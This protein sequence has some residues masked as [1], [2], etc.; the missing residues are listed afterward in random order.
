MRILGV[1]SLVFGFSRGKKFRFLFFRIRLFGWEFRFRVYFGYGIFVF[2][3]V[4]GYFGVFCSV[5]GFR[6]SSGFG[7]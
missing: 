1:W 2:R 6:I 5:L 7:Y 4:G 3:L